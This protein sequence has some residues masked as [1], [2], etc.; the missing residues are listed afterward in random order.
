[1]QKCETDVVKPGAYFTGLAI[2]GEIATDEAVGNY[3]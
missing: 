1:L 3:Q 2:M